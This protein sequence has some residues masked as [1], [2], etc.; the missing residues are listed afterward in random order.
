VNGRTPY[1]SYTYCQQSINE[2]TR[3]SIVNKNN[4]M[5]NRSDSI[6]LLALIRKLFSWHSVD[7]VMDFKPFSKDTIYI[8]IDWIANKKRVE[9]LLKT[10]FFSKEFLDYYNNIA[11]KIDKYIK[12][13]KPRNNPGIQ[14]FEMDADI[15]CA[16]QDL[17]DLKVPD[18]TITDLIISHDSATFKWSSRTVYSEFVKVRAIK[19]NQIWKIAY[20]EGFAELN[21][22]IDLITK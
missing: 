1:S 12:I 11:I 8:G 20:L 6:E 2:L 13:N 16:C 19:E 9:A 5:Q 18:L 10:D 7:T 22:L 4:G 17:P 15:W 3:E 14:S 21:D